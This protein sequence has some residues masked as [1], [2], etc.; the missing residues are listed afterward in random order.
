LGAWLIALITQPVAIKA[1]GTDSSSTRIGPNIR[2]RRL[3]CYSHV[4]KAGVSWCWSQRR[5]MC[6]AWPKADQHRLAP[7]LFPCPHISLGEL[8]AYKTICIWKI[9]K[10]DFI[11]TQMLPSILINLGLFF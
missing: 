6:R 9:S 2:P 1:S 8:S 10:V 11:L 3:P 5:G 7:S 4:S